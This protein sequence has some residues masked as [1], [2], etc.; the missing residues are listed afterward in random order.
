MAATLSSDKVKCNHCKTIVLKKNLK[1]H[2]KIVHG[3]DTKVEFL[4]TSSFDIRGLFAQPPQKIAKTCQEPAEQIHSEQNFISTHIEYENTDNA[5][6]DQNSTILSELESLKSKVEQLEIHKR[7]PIVV[8][9]AD[10]STVLNPENI[11]EMI[12]PCRSIEIILSLLPCFTIDNNTD[13]E[14]LQC[15][16]CNITLKYDFELG[17]TFDS[18]QKLPP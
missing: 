3:P 11:L 1:E 14:G 2:T 10:I 16:I 17:V 18:S 13:E 7:Q 6:K 12:S 4:S 9:R 8:N 5:E 15:K